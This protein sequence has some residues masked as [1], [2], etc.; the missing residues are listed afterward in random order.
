MPPRPRSLRIQLAVWFGG[1]SLVTLLS[2]GIV[3]GGIA[4]TGMEQAAGDDLYR[5][6]KAGA[7]L[8]AV[9]LR[10]RER[11]I[12]VLSRA[13]HFV[14]G[15]LDSNDVRQALDLRKQLS[16]EYAWIGI[17]DA[18]GKVMQSTDGVL[19]G[20]DVHERPWFIQGQ[21]G[22]Y[23]GDVHEAVLLA[24]HLPRPPDG[25]PLRLLDFAIPVYDTEHR[26]RG[27]LG[28]HLQWTWATN[29]VQNALPPDAAAQGMEV[30]ILNR[31]GNVL[32]PQRRV[33]EH[34]ARQQLGAHA[35]SVIGADGQRYLSS[36]V[37]VDTGMP[38]NLG[39]QVVVRQRLFDALAPAHAL[40][41]SLIAAGIA[42]A[43]LFSL[44][45]YLL[46]ANLARPVE[47]LA[48]AVRDIGRGETQPS[49]PQGRMTREVLRLR[50]AIRDMSRALLGHQQEL[51]T[52]NASL[53]AQV[54]ERTEAL[55][56]AN[57]ELER[58]ATHDGL[59]GVFNRRRF[60][61]KLHEMVLAA[62]R[63]GRSFALLIVDADHFKQINDVHGHQIGDEVLKQLAALLDAGTRATDFVARYGGE[64]FVVLLPETQSISEGLIVAEKIRGMVEETAFE[65]AGQVTVSIGLA[66][67]GAEANTGPALI[68][69]ADQ[70]LY[71]AKQ[72][73]RNQVVAL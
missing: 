29:T 28:A 61:E 9:G 60:D 4:T 40:R 69:R 7:D 53:E 3:V 66:V 37:T 12:R 44:V 31:Q 18:E 72:G 30:L 1:L 62:Q 38:G 33:G 59:T 43:L 19:I 41:N 21:Q 39:W 65:G 64:E 8:L 35:S 70:A 17:A 11:E 32:Y 47:A 42:A 25:Q 2:A 27:V 34:Y 55:S 22:P 13:P 51:E 67:S 6:A 23:S 36:A 63:S 57:R 5:S 24:K 68:A 49:F 50:D 15:D 58:L 54:A 71:H 56:A 26:L 16:S 73:G 45:G 48:K 46:A 10:E 14:R 52:M 20:N